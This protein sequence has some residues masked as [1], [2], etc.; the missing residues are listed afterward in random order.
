MSA[1]SFIDGDGTVITLP[2]FVELKSL[3]RM[4]GRQWGMVAQVFPSILGSG[5]GMLSPN[6]TMLYQLATF[7]IVQSML[8]Y[9][10]GGPAG[11]L[12][13]YA[14][15]AYAAMTTLAQVLG[16]R[17]LWPKLHELLHLHRDVTWFGCANNTDA[18]TYTCVF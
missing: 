6:R 7:Y 12:R 10:R 14:R 15:S 16:V 1:P 13:L 8:L 9:K 18:C 11:Q 2:A 4:F 17:K 3:P 5:V